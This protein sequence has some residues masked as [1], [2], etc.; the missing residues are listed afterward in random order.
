M[1]SIKPFRPRFWAAAAATHTVQ[2]GRAA[3]LRPLKIWVYLGDRTKALLALAHKDDEEGYTEIVACQAVGTCCRSRITEGSQSSGP[4]LLGVV[5][6]RMWT[7]ACIQV[8]DAHMRDP[9]L[10][11]LTP[12]SRKLTTERPS[13]NQLSGLVFILPYD[14]Q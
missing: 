13:A 8:N 9:W 14:S 1:P 12:V 10:Q 5:S 6:D 4:P 7:S 11:E 2:V 3:T